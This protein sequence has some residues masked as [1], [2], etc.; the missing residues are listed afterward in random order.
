MTS[1]GASWHEFAQFMTNH[2]VSE[3]NGNVLA[4]VVNG[5]GVTYH[6]RQDSRS[7]RPSLNNLLFASGIQNFDFFEE[8]I[9]NKRAFLE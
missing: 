4:A 2:L 3:I 7:S 5:Y 6:Q 1:K 8:M 9:G